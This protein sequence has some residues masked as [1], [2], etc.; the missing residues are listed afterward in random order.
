MSAILNFIPSDGNYRF[1]SELTLSDNTADVFT[2][3]V[4][5]NGRDY[6][7]GAWYFDMYDSDGILLV[8]G[9]KIVLNVSLGRR[10]AHPFFNN[11]AII[12]IDT[13]LDNL[14]PGFD[15]LGTRVQVWHFTKTDLAALITRA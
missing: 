4:R 13:S 2:F 14:D 10:A 11:N 9:V 7:D 1:S 6:N 8:A 12:A 5:W 3:D 15:D